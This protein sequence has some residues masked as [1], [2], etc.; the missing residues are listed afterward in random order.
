[1]TQPTK[2]N[3]FCIEVYQ[4]FIGKSLLKR[5]AKGLRN[6]AGK[7]HERL[8]KRRA[9]GEVTAIYSFGHFDALRRSKVAK[10]LS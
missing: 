2:T 9:A 3:Q 6:I 8:L 10:A 5:G 1:M 7:P 4:L